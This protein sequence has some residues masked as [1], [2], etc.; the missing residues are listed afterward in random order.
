MGVATRTI[1]TESENV[2]SAGLFPGLRGWP[3]RL[4]SADFPFGV[5]V[6]GRFAYAGSDERAIMVS[7]CLDLSLVGIFI[8]GALGGV[9]TN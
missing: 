6:D 5:R 1:E 9:V 2:I 3:D 8:L 7:A 4:G